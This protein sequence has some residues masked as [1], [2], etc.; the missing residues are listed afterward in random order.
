MS[1]NKPTPIDL[2]DAVLAAV[3]RKLTGYDD[4]VVVGLAAQIQV[5]AA[6]VSL[7]EVRQ[8]RTKLQAMY[9]AD[10]GGVASKLLPSLDGLLTAVRGI[11]G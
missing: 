9:A 3:E 4:L 7:A 5:L 8:A 10:P 6:P 11:V 2:A 1:T